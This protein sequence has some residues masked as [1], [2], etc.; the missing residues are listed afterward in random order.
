MQAAVAQKFR[1]FEPRN[2]PEDPLLLRH[3]EPGLEADEVPHLARPVLLPQLHHGVGLSSLT[4]G[5]SPGIPEPDGLHGTE[6]QRVAPPLRQLLDREAA[7]EVLGG[8]AIELVVGA[9]LLG[10][11]ERGHE[12]VVLRG[13]ERR[14]PVVV[15]A[16]FSVARRAEQP[17]VVE[18]VVRDDGGDRVEERERA[19]VEPPRDRPGERLRGE[20]PRGDDARRRQRGRLFPRDRDLGMGAHPPLHVVGEGDAV[21]GERG[22]ARHARG[23]RRLE[24]QAP[25]A[26]HLGLEQAV[27]AGELHRLEGIAADELGEAIGLMRR[28]H[29]DRAHLAQR[30]RDAALGQRPGGLAAGEPASDDHGRQVATCSAGA[31]SST[32]TSCPHFRHFR[33]TPV[34]P[35]APVAPVALDCFSSIPTKPQLG[36][37]IATGRFH[38]E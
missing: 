38:T 20:R 26:P 24:H 35:A 29:A 1:L 25:E 31:A 23:V 37:A 6:A 10:A 7:F 2:R 15:A 32:I 33:V 28:R 5:A 34:T 22:A 14:V 30:D 4:P 27:R 19:R 12:R 3:L 36:Q 13:R 21:H 11:A 8:R 16:A 9:V 18:R 17:V